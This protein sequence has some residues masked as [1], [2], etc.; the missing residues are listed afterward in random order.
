MQTRLDLYDN[1]WYK[2]GGSSLK[3]LLWYFVNQLFFRSGYFPV[4]GLK[5][6]LLRAFG[7]R[8]GKGV[9]IKPCVN[10]KYPWRLEIGDFVWIGED[11]WID[12]LADVKIGNHV[13]LSQGSMLLCGNHNYKNPGFDLMV[14][15]IVLEEGVWIAARALVGPGVRAHQHAMLAAGSVAAKNLEAQTI[16][17]GNPAIAIKKRSE[18]GTAA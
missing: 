12:N 11:V 5:C 13:C 9:V 7:A 4:N 18:N 14:G 15:E 3:R 6:N 10:I 8:V 17:R 16:Y 1:S 2:P